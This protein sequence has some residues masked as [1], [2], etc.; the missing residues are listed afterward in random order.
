L[1]GDGRLKEGVFSAA[2]VPALAVLAVASLFFPYGSFIDAKVAYYLSGFRFLWGTDVLGGK[3]H[4]PSQGLGFAFLCV[5]AGLMATAG[6][7][8]ASAYRRMEGQVAGRPLRW[9]GLAAVLGGMLA[10]TSPVLFLYRANALLRVVKKPSVGPGAYITLVIALAA[11]CYGMSLLYRNKTLHALDFMVLPGFLYVVVNNYIPLSGIVV[12][13]KKI[14]YRVGIFA[15]PWAGW[16]NFRFLFRSSD[17]FNIIRNT[18][19][20]NIAF[21]VTVNAAGIL[22]GYFLNE[23][24]FKHIRR[25]AQT[26][27]LLPQLISAVIISYIVYGF[28]ATDAGWVNSTLHAGV[29]NISFYSEPKYWPIILTTVNL[30]KNLG[31]SSLI[32]LSSI[33]AIDR[34]LYEAAYIDGGGKWKQFTMITMPL[35]LPTVIVLFIMSVGRIMG[36]D[37]GLFYQTTL[38]SGALYNVTQTLDVYVYRAIMETNSLGMGAAAAAFQSVVGFV[39]VLVANG[40]VRKV[41]KAHAMF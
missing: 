36:S 14:D 23:C 15:S 18:V 29:A 1:K 9:F 38:N 21:I 17:A 10:A 26:L 2:I 4:I 37:F 39:L 24:V 11:V 30:W 41:N 7:A 34:N 3:A 27:I 8:Y 20:F 35:L 19:L 32:Y 16:D 6:A 40:I 22:V 28:L 12:A 31:Y 33:V 25:V 5:G 13:F